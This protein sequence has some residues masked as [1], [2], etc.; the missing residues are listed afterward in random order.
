MMSFLFRPHRGLLDDA[1]KE[2]I[3]F[4]TKADLIKH[5]DQELSCFKHDY[6]IDDTTVEIKPYGYDKRIGWDTNIVTLKDYGVFGFTNK[7]V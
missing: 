1:M 6:K 5:I 7:S 4:H 3:E 2:V